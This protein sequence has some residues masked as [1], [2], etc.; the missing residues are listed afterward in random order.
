MRQVYRSQNSISRKGSSTNGQSDS[1]DLLPKGKLVLRSW[2]QITLYN[3]VPNALEILHYKADY[4]T[5]I[6]MAYLDFFQVSNVH[7]FHC[8]LVYLPTLEFVLV[9][10]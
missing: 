9:N 7:R 1:K 10:L 8:K 2:R 3:D 4:F 6:V 5:F